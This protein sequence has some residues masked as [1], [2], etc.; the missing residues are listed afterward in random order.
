M[1]IPYNEI[2]NSDIEDKVLVQGVVDLI[3]E[4]ENSI[5]IIDYKFSKLS[6]KVLKEK[7]AEQLKLYK[8]AVEKAFNKPVE[9]TFIYSIENAELC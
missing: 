3:I 7:Y 1:H 8:L 2:V 6:A 9:H 5:I 4:K